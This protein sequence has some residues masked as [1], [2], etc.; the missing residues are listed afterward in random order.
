MIGCGGVPW[1]VQ[2]ASSAGADRKIQ[3]PIKRL[4]KLEGETK[5]SLYLSTAGTGSELTSAVIVDSETMR[6]P[7]NDLQ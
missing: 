7:I 1:T 6:I 3:S 2:K 4:L 5:L